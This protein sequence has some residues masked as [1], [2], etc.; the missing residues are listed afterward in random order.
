MNSE[1]LVI[2]TTKWSTQPFTI[3]VIESKPYVSQLIVNGQNSGL[4]FD[5]IESILS[6]LSLKLR[7]DYIEVSNFCDNTSKLSTNH[8]NLTKIIMPQKLHLQK[9][10]MS[11]N[12]LQSITGKMSAFWTF[13]ELDLSF[14]Q[15]TQ[16]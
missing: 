16:I 13:T 11:N 1:F 14:N 3:Q 8:V 7:F 5:L 12:C 9:I 4:P 6:V 15:F 2:K 10:K